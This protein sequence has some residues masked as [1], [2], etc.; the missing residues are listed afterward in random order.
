MSE[1]FCPKPEPFFFFI[2]DH[3]P[4]LLYYSHIPAMVLSLLFGMLVFWKNRESIEARLIFFIT[5][6][7]FFWAF[8]DI[9]LWATNDSRQVM[10]F[11]SMQIL[12][13]LGIYVASGYLAYVFIKEKD[14]PFFGKILSFSPLVLLAYFLPTKETLSYFVL[15]EACE[16]IEGFVAVQY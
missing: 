2:S 12:F 6:L 5:I 15:D 1:I 16:A 8:F 13:E 4:S 3:V 10:F 11:W 9:I 7:F 14:M